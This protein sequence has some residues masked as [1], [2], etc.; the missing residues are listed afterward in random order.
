MDMERL[1]Q[2]RVLLEDVTPLRD[3]CGRLCGGACCQGERGDAHGMLLFPGEAALYASA[4]WAQVTPLPYALGGAPAL[5]LTCDGT[6]PRAQR[7]LACRLFPLF[8][9]MRDTGADV[10]L[11]PRARSVCPLFRYGL[12]GLSQ[13]FIQAARAAYG[14][15]AQDAE[16]CAFLQD[17]SDAYSL[18]VTRPAGGAR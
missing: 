6:C 10:T 18:G 9:R 13:D 17:L 4:A 7:P 16:G 1:V 11:D 3:D 14:L 15:L 12:Q 2:A 5:L 8:C